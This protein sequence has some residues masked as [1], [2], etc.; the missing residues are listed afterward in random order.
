MRKAVAEVL[1]LEPRGEVHASASMPMPALE[2]PRPKRPTWPTLAALAIV[3]GIG[4]VGLGA[5]A[6]FTE[7]REDAGT[8]AAT[9]AETT[10]DPAMEWSLA[11]LADSKVERYPLEHSVERIAL[12]VDRRGRA[13]ITL[14]GLGLPPEGSIYQA[15]LVQ[16]GSATPTA[17]ATFDASARVIPLSRTVAHGARVGVTLERGDGAIRPSRPLRLVALRP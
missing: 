17:V 10:A 9:T 7:V 6:V 12:V 5:W 13:V 8:T 4:A 3:S 1:E 2:V 14:D 11:V 16:P 15:W